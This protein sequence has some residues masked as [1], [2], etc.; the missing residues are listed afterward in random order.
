M[1]S[2]GDARSLSL[3]DLASGLISQYP[4]PGNPLEHFHQSWSP[5][6]FRTGQGNS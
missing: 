3:W 4:N 2:K 5:L 6:R 1:G